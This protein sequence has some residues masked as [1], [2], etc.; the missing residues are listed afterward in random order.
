MSFLRARCCITPEVSKVHVVE[1][2][3]VLKPGGIF[4]AAREHVISRESILKNSLN[5][6]RCII[7]M[8]NTHFF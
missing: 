5:S 2:H 6:I 7:F 1:M 8:G 3:R 4:I